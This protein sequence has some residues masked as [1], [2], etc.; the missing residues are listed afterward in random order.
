[1]AAGVLT[2]GVP[3]PQEA[4]ILPGLTTPAFDVTAQIP[5]LAVVLPLFLLTQ[6]FTLARTG[7]AA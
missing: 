2:Y 5:C 3:D 4:G 6:R 1:M 7:T